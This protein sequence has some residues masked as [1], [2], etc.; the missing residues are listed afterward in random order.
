M[1]LDI[2]KEKLLMYVMGTLNMTF[3]GVFKL[4]MAPEISKEN[5]SKTRGFERLKLI[6]RLSNHYRENIVF[7]LFKAP[8]D[9]FDGF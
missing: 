7:R 5:M 9:G 4:I 2:S 3:S 1:A 6:N 8:N